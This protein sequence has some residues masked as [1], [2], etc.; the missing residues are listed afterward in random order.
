MQFSTCHFKKHDIGL[1]DISLV[2]LYNLPAKPYDLLLVAGDPHVPV[3]AGQRAGEGLAPHAL[4][5]A[6]RLGQKVVGVAPAAPE[7]K[8]GGDVHI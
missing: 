2:Q 5:D 8:L 7:E 3:E 4:G 6:V 1:Q